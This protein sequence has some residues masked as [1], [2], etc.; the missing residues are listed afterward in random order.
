MV[1]GL[2]HFLFFNNANDSSFR[3]IFLE[4]AMR[5]GMLAVI[6]ASVFA[7]TAVFA[8]ENPQNT[9]D[10]PVVMDCPLYE[11]PDY[12]DAS[13][14]MVQFTVLDASGMYFF[15]NVSLERLDVQVRTDG[16][17]YT[18]LY[19]RRIDITGRCVGSATILVPLPEDVAIWQAEVN[20]WKAIRQRY[21]DNLP[22]P[23]RVLPRS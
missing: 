3:F 14:I 6:A 15:M 13:C 21:L 7:V 1:Q 8:E 12:T 2:D 23:K 16:K 10:A 22:K 4:D 11:A 18:S 5:I 20:R 19:C 9:V 17:D